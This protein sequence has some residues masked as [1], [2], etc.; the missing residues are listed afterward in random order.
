MTYKEI[1]NVIE[2]LNN[3]QELKKSITVQ[4]VLIFLVAFENDGADQTTIIKKAGLK[5]AAGS[6]HLRM[7]SKYDS[8]NKREGFG[9]LDIVQDSS[10]LSSNIITITDKGGLIT[11]VLNFVKT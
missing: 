10:N 3:F 6:K 9:L 4:Q 11:K 8:Y 2:V 7:Y 5:T 1:R